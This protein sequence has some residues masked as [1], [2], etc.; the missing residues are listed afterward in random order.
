MRLP[1]CLRYSVGKQKSPNKPINWKRQ[2]TGSKQVRMS[3]AG[4]PKVPNKYQRIIQIGACFGL[5]LPQ[6]I[7]RA[8]AWWLYDTQG[9]VLESYGIIKGTNWEPKRLKSFTKLGHETKYDKWQL[10]DHQI[11]LARRWY[12]ACAI[13][14]TAY[15]QAAMTLP[16]NMIRIASRARYMILLLELIQGNASLIVMVQA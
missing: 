6:H 12:I 13:A 3:Q 16:R 8:G 4:L 5:R 11:R 15:L 1:S 10:G 7:V 2:P 14:F 9:Y